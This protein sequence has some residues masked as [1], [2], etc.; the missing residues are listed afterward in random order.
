MSDNGQQVYRIRYGSR[1]I[2]FELEYRKRKTLEI[3]VH[4]DTSVQVVAPLDRTLDEIR[5]KLTGSK[6]LISIA[7]GVTT[8]G[9]EKMA[10]AELPVVRA[11]PNT[12]VLVNMGMTALAGGRF[13]GKRHLDAAES[14]FCRAG[15]VARIREDQMNAFTAVS[16][17]GPAYLFLLAEAMEKAGLDAGL[18]VEIT[19][20]II[21]Q[22]LRGA[23]ELLAGEGG[24]AGELRA[25][26]TSPGGTT[27]A[28]VETLTGAG[29]VELF[30]RAIRNAVRRAG[31][32]E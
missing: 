6:L 12:P 25:A 16:G 8:A 24:K 13:A 26:V 9:I 29:F 31:E 7:A 3:S 15:K 11:M 4:P 32:L 2:A 5:E 23:A 27:E 14:I 28:A 17:S 21:P 22:T 1:M 18:G 19:S 30:A 10:G 20:L